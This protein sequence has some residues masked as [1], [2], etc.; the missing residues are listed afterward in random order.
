MIKT[1]PET[2]QASA[3][4]AGQR[5]DNQA[6]RAGRVDRHVGQRLR[7]RRL[8]LGLSQQDVAALL[9]IAYQ[10]VQKYESG[11][12]R[13]SAGRLYMLSHIL[14][15]PVGDF[16]DGLPPVE[17]MITEGDDL[18]EGLSALEDLPNDRLRKALTGLVKAIRESRLRGPAAHQDHHGQKGAGQRT[19][20]Q[21]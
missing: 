20:E 17:T 10:Q 19:T 14:Q 5:P 6:R 7:Q 12:N 9:G 1:N 3:P 21:A 11:L 18:A 15:M 8:A 16:F 2:V 4:E 13:L